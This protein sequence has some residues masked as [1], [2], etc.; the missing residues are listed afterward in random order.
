MVTTTAAEAA[1]EVQALFNLFNGKSFVQLDQ[2]FLFGNHIHHLL[3]IVVGLDKR[4]WE[5]RCSPSK[6]IGFLIARG[7]FRVKKS[8]GKWAPTLLETGDD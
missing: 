6:P 7:D 5:F 2:F 4:V 8:M 1:A 3:K